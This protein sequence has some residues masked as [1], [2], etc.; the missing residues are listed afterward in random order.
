LRGD[1]GG[2]KTGSPQSWLWIC[3][4]DSTQN[5]AEGGRPPTS[6]RAQSS[7][8]FFG[9]ILNPI[10]Q[11]CK[12]VDMMLLCHYCCC[13]VVIIIIVVVVA[14]AAGGGG[15]GVLLMLLLKII[16]PL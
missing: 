7:N 15:G 2:W 14:A 9:S 10:V 4:P 1:D 16:I 12:S 5:Q 3:S 6:R 11:H 13:Y 8:L